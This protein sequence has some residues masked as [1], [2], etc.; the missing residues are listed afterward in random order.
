[1]DLGVR[2]VADPAQ[3]REMDARV[4]KYRGQLETLR[5]EMHTAEA[6]LSDRDKLF[7]GS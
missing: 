7:A 6:E 5:S 4:R 3:R 2:S 1:M